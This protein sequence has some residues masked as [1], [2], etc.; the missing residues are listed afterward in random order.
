MQNNLV[1]VEDLIINKKDSQIIDYILLCEVTFDKNLLNDLVYNKKIENI[2]NQIEESI[3]SKI[4][5]EYNFVE[6]E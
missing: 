4:Q 2:V 3:I 6:Y 5:N 1:T